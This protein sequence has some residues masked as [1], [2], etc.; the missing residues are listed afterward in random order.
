MRSF[1]YVLLHLFRMENIFLHGTF[2][3]S[4]SLQ[5]SL[6]TL[7]LKFN[8]SLSHIRSYL[9]LKLQ[10]GGLYIDLAFLISQN[11]LNFFFQSSW[12]C[13]GVKDCSLGEDEENCKMTC[14]DETQFACNP[15]NSTTPTVPGTRLKLLPTHALRAHRTCIPK[16]R[17]CNGKKDCP[18]G[19][20]NEHNH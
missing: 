4:S 10:I 2:G 1:E 14:S 16:N 17:V 18:R 5:S 6:S 9:D 12:V 19:E 20:G 11:P 15:V 8:S 3:S 7:I 13:D